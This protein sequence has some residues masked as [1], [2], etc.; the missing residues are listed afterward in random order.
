[1]RY[2]DVLMCSCI[3]LHRSLIKLWEREAASKQMNG[4]YSGLDGANFSL[5]LGGLDPGGPDCKQEP[6]GGHR[7]VYPNNVNHSHQGIFNITLL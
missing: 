4:G 7:T 6:G 1:M 2:Y 5:G 3:F